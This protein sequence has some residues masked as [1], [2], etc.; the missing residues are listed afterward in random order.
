MPHRQRGL[1][2][3][4]HV[5][6]AQTVGLSR[7]RHSRHGIDRSAC[8]A[9]STFLRSFARRALPRVSAH[10]NALTPGQSAL[11]VLIRDN[12]L[13]PCTRPGLLVSC[14][15]PSGRSASNHLLPPPGPSLVSTRSLPRGLP[16]ASVSGTLAS[17]GLRLYPA[18]SPRQPA[19]SSSSSCGPIVHLQLLSTPSR[20]D[21]VTFGYEVQTQPRQGLAPC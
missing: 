17:F 14:I 12:E 15:K 3:P 2:E 20:E 21:A 5:C 9:A 1:S 19:E 11:R 4:S 6:L 13:R 7:C 8:H 16:T 10:M 18:G